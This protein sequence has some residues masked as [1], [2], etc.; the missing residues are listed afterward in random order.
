MFWN[1]AANAVQGVFLNL[2]R[3][4]EL[5]QYIA[6]VESGKDKRRPRSVAE[7]QRSLNTHRE[8]NRYLKE[9]DPN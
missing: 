9:R 3:I 6:K 4:A 2:A 5:D 8:E 1:L 7:Y